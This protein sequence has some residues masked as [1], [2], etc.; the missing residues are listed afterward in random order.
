MLYAL[1]SD[2]LHIPTVI[3]KLLAGV[4]AFQEEGST[5]RT[6]FDLGYAVRGKH[7]INNHLDFT[8]LVHKVPAMY[9]NG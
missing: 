6:G 1:H 4:S 2:I 7:Y 9:S 3:H 5:V 8:I